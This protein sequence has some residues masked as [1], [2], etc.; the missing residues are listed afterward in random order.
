MVRI[1][2]VCLLAS[3]C[4]AVACARGGTPEL[5]AVRAPQAAST[6]AMTEDGA[7]VLIAHEDAARISVFDVKAQK[8]VSTLQCPAPR[9]ILCRGG[10]AY[11]ANYGKGTITVFDRSKGWALVNEVLTTHNEVYYLSAPAGNH[12][13][14]T[15]LASCGR[16]AHHA[17]Y[18]V[19]VA[20]DHAKQVR[21]EMYASVATA[22][23]DGK[24]V[25]LQGEFRMSPS[26]TVTA[27]AM[28]TFLTQPRGK[29]QR[30]EHDPTPLLYQVGEG[31]WWFGEVCLYAGIPPKPFRGASGDWVIPDVTRPLF[32]VLDKGVVRTHALDAGT[33]ELA[34]AKVKLP[35]S[36]ARKRPQV[37]R[38][39]RRVSTQCYGKYVFH[40]PVAATHGR[41]AH[42]FLYDEGA[43][44]VLQCIV[45]A[46]DEAA[47][48]AA[49]APAPPEAQGGPG[50]F[51]K[52]IPEGRALVFPLYAG[53]VQGAFTVVQG[54]KG[55]A[56]SPA[57]ELRWTPAPGDKGS[58]R[59][60]IR[61]EVAG[62]VSFIRIET[63]VVARA[64][65]PAARAKAFPPK[66]PI[67]QKLTFQLYDGEVKGK[68]SLVRG[69]KGIR[70][71]D[72]GV[73]TWT[74][75][76][77][78]KGPHRIAIKA[79]IGGRL[80]VV[81]LGTYVVADRAATVAGGKP[82][83][84]VAPPP[85]RE[86]AEFKPIPTEQVASTMAVAEDGAHVLIAHEAAGQISVWD[87]RAQKVV[88]TLRCPTPRHILCRARRAFVAN[89]GHATISVFDSRKGW[90]M[91]DQV[92]V[93][94]KEVYYLSAP[95]G[96]EFKGKVLASAGKYTDKTFYVVDVARDRSKQVHKEVYASVA[97][98]SYDGDYIVVQSEFGHSPSAVPTAYPSRAFLAGSTEGRKRGNHDSTPFLYQV[99]KGS[100]WFGR[101][102]IYAGIPPKPFGDAMGSLIIPNLTRPVFHVIQGNAVYTH[103]LHAAL[104]KL[105]TAK[106]AFPAKW[107]GP[108]GGRHRRSGPL[109]H[110]AAATLGEATYLFE[111]DGGTQTVYQ[112]ILGAIDDAV[113]AAKPPDEPA[114][115][116]QPAKPEAAEPVGAENFPKRILEG[117]KLSCKLFADPVQG[118]F[119]LVEG[120]QGVTLSKGGRLEWTPGPKDRGPQRLKIRAEIGGDVS[121]IRIAT[122]VVGKEVA[123]LV[124][125]DV[126]RLDDLGVHYILAGHCEVAPSASRGH[127]VVRMGRK[128]MVLDAAGL[129]V[130]R[131]GELDDLYGRLAERPDAYVAARN[132]ALRLLDKR[133][134]KPKREIELPGSHV[135]DLALHP[136][137]RACYV[138]VQDNEGGRLNPILAR[139]VAWVDETRGTVKVLDRILGQW[140]AVHPS[141]KYLF[142]AIHETYRAG[143]RFDPIV[144]DFL[145]N[146][147]DIDILLSYDLQGDRARHRHTNTRAGDNGR[148]LRMAPDGAL[149]AYVSGGGYPDHK[150]YTIPAFTAEDIR[151][152]HV[153]YR[154]G[155]YP[156]D[157]AFHPTLD[158]VAATGGGTPAI[159][160]R[161]T[162]ETLANKLDLGD[163]KLGGVARIV[164]TP[165][166]KHLLIDSSDQSKRRALRSFALRLTDEE[167]QRLDK[168]PRKPI[169]PE[170]VDADDRDARPRTLVPLADL[171][172][173]RAASTE[174]MD[175][176]AIARAFMSSVVIIKSDKGGGTGFVVGSKGYVLT[177]AHVLPILGDPEITYR[178]EQAGRVVMR[179]AK[180]AIVGADRQLDLALLKIEAA[181]PLPVVRL[182]AEATLE[183]GEAVCTIG[184]PGLGRKTLDYTMTQGIISN[185]ARDIEGTAYIQTNATVNPGSSGSPLFDSRGN[186]IGLVVLKANIESTGFAVPVHRLA[187]FVRSHARAGGAATVRKPAPKVEA[188]AAAAR[189]CRS[190]LSMARQFR[191]AGMKDKARTYLQRVLDEHPGTPFAAEAQSLLEGL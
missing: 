49:R 33:A 143:Y 109:Y 57:G 119:A 54:P 115:P 2:H 187:A 70:I 74:P 178:A 52:Q 176:R 40:Y 177:C 83:P 152:L 93:G 129:T 19:D 61:A 116:T 191:K 132:G 15:V 22:S 159:Y 137:Q 123:K 37:S 68:F 111:F 168:G 185:R 136:R 79:V 59:I 87:V 112:C 55:I 18:A 189:K 88:A 73:L 135:T 30:G 114:K 1:P 179:T 81:Q 72:A 80:S 17:F 102:R 91:V 62:K 44:A 31:A 171:D 48:V 146:Y 76:A 78:E 165:D 5:E 39:R 113:V 188:D 3:L 51:P 150:G 16:Y 77:R 163:R 108:S 43:R 141:G 60:K 94:R 65:G 118:T 104:T 148:A 174:A 144:R 155:P 8:L 180:A 84:E 53:K 86:S 89:Y 158:L 142:T 110:P 45:E 13:K 56:V 117:K 138:A 106:V 125:G 10:K 95:G 100:F 139:K 182:D 38:G 42:L 14:G 122:E 25:A 172:G 162:G 36:W 46:A 32:Y 173:L 147:E 58:H 12:F 134:L 6:L 121:F 166:G 23:Y 124:E 28:E 96:R 64:A 184:H 66:V 47:L 105:G 7:C 24:H 151:N 75:S 181:E 21:T 126:T 11:V 186:V 85:V 190:W 99:H 183:V 175:A 92:L 63:E 140:L 9:F 120:P 127:I 161:K 67:G 133:T 154:L 128:L 101:N 71:S 160:S 164:F 4:L 145:R 69:P 27:Y 29:G 90:K 41:Q 131:T 103:R 97:T 50:H 26:A 35:A 34:S 98:S 20:G 157:V 130:T 169:A 156:C 170:L 107:K 153:A 82:P 167:R 149:V